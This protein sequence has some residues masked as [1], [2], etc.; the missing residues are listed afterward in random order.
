MARLGSYFILGLVA[1]MVS[2]TAYWGFCQFYPPVAIKFGYDKMPVLKKTVM[3]GE[4]LPIHF[5]FEKFVTGTTTVK[6]KFINGG[7]FSLTEATIYRKAGRYDFIGYDI[8]VPPHL[9]P[10][11]YYLQNDYDL[12]VN[13]FRMDHLSIQSEKFMV[14]VN[15]D[16]ALDSNSIMLKEIDKKISK[17]LREWPGMA[18]KGE[19]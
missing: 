11:E 19:K 14:T 16:L 9:P 13:R 6:R 17:Y 8:V 2:F 4:G 18:N 7:L 5:I 15:P 10:G 12:P 1:A 3:Q